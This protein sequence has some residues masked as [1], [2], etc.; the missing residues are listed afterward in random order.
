MTRCR[1]VRKNKSSDSI[2]HVS[3]FQPTETPWNVRNRQKLNVILVFHEAAV[4]LNALENEIA[5]LY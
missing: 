3:V 4:S 2:R 1:K 5:R